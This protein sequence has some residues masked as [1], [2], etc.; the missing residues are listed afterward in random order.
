[1]GIA[2]DHHLAEMLRIR[3]KLKKTD[4]DDDDEEEEENE[5]EVNRWHHGN[6]KESR[7]YL[8]YK[9]RTMA[10][11]KMKDDDDDDEEIFDEGAG[12]YGE[13]L[14][15]FAYDDRLDKDSE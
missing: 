2:R 5:E 7:A 8:D 6:P 15:M 11:L 10:Q 3:M 14:T 4:D 1:M 12:R 13:K 9:K